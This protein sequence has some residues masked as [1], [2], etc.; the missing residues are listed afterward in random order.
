MKSK[1]FVIQLIFLL[2]ST[3]AVAQNNENKH[4]RFGLR[5]GVYFSRFT[6]KDLPPEYS[7]PKG[8]DA[9][10]AG[11][12]VDIPLSTKLSLT[13]EALYALSSSQSYDDLTRNLYQDEL[14]HI[15]V[16]AMLKYKFG[17]VG[18]LAGVQGE[19]LLS[20]NGSYIEDNYI[21]NGDIKDRSYKGFGMSGVLGAEWV[22]KYRF[23]IDA[24]YQFGLT[25]IRASNGSTLMTDYGTIKANAF[26]AGIFY[27]FGKKPLKTE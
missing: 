16:P 12:Q 5:A 25:D 14:S 4:V 22:F 2:I 24:R 9:F 15:L 26:Q 20:A 11:V 10:Y 19:F 13:T 18:L 6:F 3:L 23:G 7:K 27:R 21:R 8:D 17:K 1:H